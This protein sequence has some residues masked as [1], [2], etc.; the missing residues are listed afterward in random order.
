MAF[1]SRLRSGGEGSTGKPNAVTSSLSRAHSWASQW[2]MQMGSMDPPFLSLLHL[3]LGKV[4]SL[5]T[6]DQ[7]GNG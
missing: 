3:T 4:V 7:R 6:Q 2:M 5:S 1:R